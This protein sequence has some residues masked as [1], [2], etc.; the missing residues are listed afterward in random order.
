MS[1]FIKR[2][3]IYII[4][5]YIIYIIYNIFII[6]TMYKTSYR[7]LMTWS[8][9]IAHHVPKCRV[10]IRSLANGQLPGGHIVCLFDYIYLLYTYYTLHKHI[11]ENYIYNRIKKWR[12]R[13]KWRPK[14]AYMLDFDETR[15]DGSVMVAASTFRSK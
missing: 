3:F 11:Y 6:Y 7:W 9:H 15:R 2:E 4:Y 8:A 13:C 12:K 1:A 14:I 10:I 5:I